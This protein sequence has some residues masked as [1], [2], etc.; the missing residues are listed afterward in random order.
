VE[1]GTVHLRVT[2]GD[3]ARCHFAWSA[4]SEKSVPI[5]EEFQAKSSGWFGAKVG[6]FSSALLDSNDQGYADFGWFGVTGH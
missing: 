1:G 5:G 4:D 6:L 3:N 2:V